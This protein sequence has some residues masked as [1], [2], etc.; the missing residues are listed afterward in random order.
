M[1]VNKKLIKKRKEQYGDNFPKI[2]ESWN[3]Y[4]FD[5][6]PFFKAITK[7]DVAMLMAHMKKTRIKNILKHQ[8]TNNIHRLTSNFD[9]MN[10]LEKINFNDKRI[11]FINEDLD[12]LFNDINSLKDNI[13][14][15]SNYVWIANNYEEYERL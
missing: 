12:I 13:E 5:K 15:F 11:E 10:K 9:Y 2:A 3:K 6:N 8:I 7:E 14:D 4:F 1:K